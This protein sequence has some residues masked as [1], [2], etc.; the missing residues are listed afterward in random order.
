M[1]RIIA[2]FLVLTTLLLT[3]CGGSAKNAA[4]ASVS[5]FPAESLSGTYVGKNGSA[6]TLFPDG[7]SEYCYVLQSP[8]NVDEGAGRWSY[9]DGTLTW[10]YNDKPITASINEQNTLSFTLEQTNEW[11][12]ETFVKVS[13]SAESK[14]I[15]QCRNIVQEALGHPE[16]NGFDVNSNSTCTLSGI[17]FSIPSYW[18]KI[19]DESGQFNYAAEYFES[20]NS[21]SSLSI[22]STGKKM[23]EESFHAQAF[24]LGNKLVSGT[25]EKEVLISPSLKKINNIEILTGCRR[26]Y[27]SNSSDPINV[28]F[29]VINNPNVDIILVMKLETDNTIFAYSSDFE[30][31]IQSISFESA[32][33]VS[34]NKS[35]IVENNSTG[36]TPEL[37][38]FLDSYE[39]FID[40]YIAFMQKYENS[41]DAYGM[42]YDYL[43]M[44]QQY[45]D[46]AEKIDQYDTDQ[47]SDV[48]SAY[49]LEVTMRVAKKLY[50]VA[51]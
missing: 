38:A 27:L 3:A 32:G 45:A 13:N 42:L 4:P 43:D 16:M 6:L 1:K 14:S 48:D 46:F 18:E 30:K 23:S 41:D 29:A 31:I 8:S 11:T 2:A 22:A 33:K 36:V 9:K 25:A 47:M 12:R 34:E 50:S 49:Y 5:R 17:T 51:T 21:F 20:E 15:S 37:K 24:D 39:A 28:S 7:T 35:S 44:M 26:D 40:Q 10:M 19:T